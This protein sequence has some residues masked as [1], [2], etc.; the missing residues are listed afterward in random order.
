MDSYA[1]KLP[2][3]KKNTIHYRSDLEAREIQTRTHTHTHTPTHSS[4]HDSTLWIQVPPKKI[5]SPPNCTLSAFLA[6]T[7]IHRARQFVL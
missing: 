3:K 1:E 2:E 4:T 5:L 6:A 7:W